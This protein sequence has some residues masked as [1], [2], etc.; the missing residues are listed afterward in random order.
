MKIEVH[1]KVLCVHVYNSFAFNHP[2]LETTQMS[3]SWQIYFLK[4]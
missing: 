4:L 2:K 1:I 3:I